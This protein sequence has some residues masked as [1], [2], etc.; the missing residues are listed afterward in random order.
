MDGGGGSPQLVGVR[1]GAGDRFFGGGCCHTERR[2]EGADELFAETSWMQVMIGQHVMPRAYHPLVD[3]LSMDEIREMVAGTR[4]VLE[5]SVEVMPTHNEFIARFC[6]A[7]PVE[8][9]APMRK[10]V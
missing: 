3:T 4:R 8:L 5:R 10:V 6:K 2:F 7:K 9:A 1:V